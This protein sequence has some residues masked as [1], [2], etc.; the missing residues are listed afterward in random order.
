MCKHQRTLLYGIG[1]GN[2]RDTRMLD[3]YSSIA[4]LAREDCDLDTPKIVLLPTAHRNGTQRRLPFR[5]Y[6]ASCF[7]KRGCRTCEILVGDVPAKERETPFG[8]V[9]QLLEDADALFV[10][11][12]DTRH[13]LSVLAARDLLPV[14][15]QSYEGGL[16]FSGSSAGLIWLAEHSMSDS[17]SFSTPEQWR[18]IILKGLG[19]LPLALNVHDDQGVC[20]GVLP[21]V[22]RR[23][24]FEERLRALDDP[25][26]LAVDEFVALEVRHGRCRVRSHRAET[27]AYVLADIGGTLHR[28][29]IDTVIDLL[30]K[31]SLRQYVKD[32]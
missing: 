2:P 28:R 21:R 10:L 6:I 30:D 25:L 24:Q 13:L 32:R 16:L 15:K 18:F 9:E 27:G 20:D 11:G 14:F 3:H 7:E 5:R 17:D 19:V 1:G 22:S 26:G 31:P 29:R 12:G 8:D 23:V 4:E